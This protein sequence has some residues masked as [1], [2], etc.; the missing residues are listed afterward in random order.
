VS[1]LV[2]WALGTGFGIPA[3]IALA[4]GWVHRSRPTVV[5]HHH[6]GPRP[7]P[8]DWQADERLAAR[9]MTGRD[10]LRRQ[11]PILPS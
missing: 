5:H 7:L 11:G 9:A 2:A 3:G 1:T 4:L 8:A 10:F 6:H